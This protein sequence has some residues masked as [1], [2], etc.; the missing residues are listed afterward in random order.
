MS[1]I[2]L[3]LMGGVL[4]QSGGIVPGFLGDVRARQHA[5]QF[6]DAVLFV[7]RM[8]VGVV[9]LFHHH[10]VIVPQGSHLRCVCDTDD[11]GMTAQISQNAAHGIGCGAA[12]TNVCFVED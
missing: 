4:Q 5:R 9:S 11:L 10:V 6:F 3:Q 1:I 8:N 2:S 12:N 7:Q